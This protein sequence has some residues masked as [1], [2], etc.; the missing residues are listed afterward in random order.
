M[1]NR[2]RIRS[3]AIENFER[4]IVR[5]EA[6]VIARWKH[7]IDAE[8][9]PAL[10]N[11][12]D[13]WAM[14]RMLDTSDRA[15]RV[16]EA[17]QTTSVFGTN[18]RNA[19]L[20]MTRQVFPRLI[21]TR[22]AAVQ[23]VDRPTSTIFHLSLKRDDASTLGKHP[24][25]DMSG[26]VNPATLVSRAYADDP[27]EGQAIT[28]G[29]ALSIAKTDIAIGEA[30]KLETEATLEL[31]Q[32][33]QAYHNLNALDLLQGAA[34]DEIAQEIDQMIVKAAYDAATAHKT[35]TFGTTAPSSETWT[36]GEWRKRLQRAILVA[37][38]AIYKASGRRP[39][40]IVCGPQAFLELNDLNSFVLS[41]DANWESGNYG[42]QYVGTLSNQYEVLMS[43]YMP[44]SEMLL[45]RRGN[46][47]LDAGLVYAPYIALFV[48]E[49]VFNTNTQK[50]SQSFASRFG[51][52]TIS[53]TLFAKVVIDEGAEGIA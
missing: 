25:E 50:T 34:T 45:A 35:V 24:Y 39:N 38:S 37:D 18:Y 6:D 46:G 53:N 47:F 7:F 42:L 13:R 26:V 52:F 5:G 23:P 8:G 32:D 48:S 43:R 4:Q 44:D 10:E 33:L 12:F 29:M 41:P 19:L 22:L 3:A 28:K 1:S 17:T 15:L 16:M 14:A 2:T 36:N 40:V 11:E 49:R 31:Q 27:G 51:L 20:G 30:R 9:A 21:G